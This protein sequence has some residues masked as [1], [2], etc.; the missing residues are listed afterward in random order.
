MAIQFK[1]TVNCNTPSSGNTICEAG[2]L[3]VDAGDAIV[4]RPSFTG[5]AGIVSISDSCGQQWHSRIRLDGTLTAF[6]VDDA[7]AGDCTITLT[8]QFPEGRLGL[9]A[10]SYGGVESIGEV[11]TGPQ[12]VITTSATLTVPVQAAGNYVLGFLTSSNTFQLSV[13]AGQGALRA[14]VQRGGNTIGIADTIAT[15]PGNT[16]LVFT[17]NPAGIVFIYGL[18]LT[19]V[20]VS[21]PE[22][23]PDDFVGMSR[24]A[25]L[26]PGVV[27]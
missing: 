19:A 11:I 13:A 2:P 15:D 14:F 24:Y 20:P 6:V 27:P 3:H 26:V 18:E 12:S 9:A 17:L 8:S 21:P 4:V 22:P 1:N 10:V 25:Q 16:D 5:S 7:I 23:E